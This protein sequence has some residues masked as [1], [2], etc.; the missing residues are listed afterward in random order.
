MNVTDAMTHFSHKQHARHN[1]WKGVHSA[2]IIFYGLF[3]NYGTSAEVK[4]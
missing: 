2:D 4:D 3:E 1:T